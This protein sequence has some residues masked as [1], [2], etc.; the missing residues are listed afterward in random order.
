MEFQSSDGE[1]GLF[2][3]GRWGMKLVLRALDLMNL[4]CVCYVEL[5]LRG[6]RKLLNGFYIKKSMK[7]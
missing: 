2:I 6:C 7:V 1:A 4:N 3:D 5:S